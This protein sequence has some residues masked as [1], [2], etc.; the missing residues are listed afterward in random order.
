LKSEAEIQADWEARHEAIRAAKAPA[1]PI[2]LRAIQAEVENLLRL[3]D[4]VASGRVPLTDFLSDSRPGEANVLL[5]LML[6]RS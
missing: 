3:A 5:A 6:N 2:I 4:G 1:V